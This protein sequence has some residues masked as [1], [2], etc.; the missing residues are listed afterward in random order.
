MK[1]IKIPG[2]DYE[3]S[4]YHCTQVEWVREMGNNPS[5]FE[6]SNNPVERVSWNDVQEFIKKKNEIKDGYEYRLPNEDEWEH[7]CRAG[8]KTNYCFGNSEE[9]LKEY[10]LFYKNSDGKTHPVGL[11]K[12]NAWGLYDM[13]GN[14]WEWCADLY[15]PWSSNRVIRGGSWSSD[16]RDA[17]SAY[18]VNGGPADRGSVLGFRLAR[19]LLSSPVTLPKSPV[20]REAK[21]TIPGFEINRIRVPGGW[22]Y[23]IKN[24]SNSDF[25]VQFVARVNKFSGGKE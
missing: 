18:R 13:H 23:I 17:R 16:A 6:G 3:M 21:A 22:I 8:S 1:F 25:K 10:A 11:K 9:E 5:K 14:V 24:I 19:T 2:R 12:P 4:A 7:A 20:A 15:S